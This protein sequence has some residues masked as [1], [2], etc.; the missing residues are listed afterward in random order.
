MTQFKTTDDLQEHYWSVIVPMCRK[1]NAEHGTDV[2]SWE[3]VR[4]NG[5]M[6]NGGIEQHPT[7]TCKPYEYTFALTILEGKP[8]FPGVTIYSKLST[9]TYCVCESITMD[10]VNWTLTPPTKKR[11]FMLELNEQERNVLMHLSGTSYSKVLIG[12]Y[13]KLAESRDKE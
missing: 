5:G 13:D 1:Y 11:T 2:K 12:L 3:C 7:F 10:W 9:D 6:I 4:L 8:L